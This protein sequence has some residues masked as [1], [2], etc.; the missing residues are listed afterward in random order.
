MMALDVLCYKTFDDKSSN[1]YVLLQCAAG[2]NWKS[3]PIHIGRWT[4]CIYYGHQTTY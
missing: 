4:T 2:N 3:E 1:L